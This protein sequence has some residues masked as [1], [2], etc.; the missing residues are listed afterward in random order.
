MANGAKNKMSA[1]K[2]SK[3]GPAAGCGREGA[4]C[5]ADSSAGR[6]RMCEKGLARG[7]WVP[8]YVEQCVHAWG[9]AAAW[10]AAG[11]G[12]A[13]RQGGQGRAGLSISSRLDVREQPRPGQP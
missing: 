9:C 4:P 10:A 5:T 2:G 7:E 1:E 6:G 13:W 3:E 11:L 12:W 8:G